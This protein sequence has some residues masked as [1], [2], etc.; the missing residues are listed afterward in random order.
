MVV[1][2]PLT[3]ESGFPTLKVS[4]VDRSFHGYSLVLLDQLDD[5]TRGH[6]GGPPIG[7]SH[8]DPLC[9]NFLHYGLSH[10]AQSAHSGLFGYHASGR[11]QRALLAGSEHVGGIVGV[12]PFPHFA[13]DDQV[14][15]GIALPH[16][17]RSH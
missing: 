2:M 16:R 12:L 7:I 9:R 5:F 10:S 8:A 4:R 15:F 17:C 13:G 1:A 6:A 14:H 11:H 3:V